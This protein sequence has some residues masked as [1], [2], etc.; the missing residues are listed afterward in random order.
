MGNLAEGFSEVQIT[1]E[2][3]FAHHQIYI[4]ENPVRAGLARSAEEYPY[5]STYLKKRK[6]EAKSR[7][8]INHFAVRLKSYP[9]TCCGPGAS[10]RSRRKAFFSA[11]VGMAS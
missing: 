4:D 8:M 2:A 5:C 10:F 3:S 1:T 7:K 9:V 6:A 11:W